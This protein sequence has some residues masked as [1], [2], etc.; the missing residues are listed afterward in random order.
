M[1]RFV[2]I[3]CLLVLFFSCSSDP[4]FS[5]IER[6]IPLR[7]FTVANYVY[8]VVEFDGKFYASHLAL[9]SKSSSS[10]DGWNRITA[11]DNNRSVLGLAVGDDG[12]NLY[13]LSI[14]GTVYYR[15]KG[16]DSWTAVTGQPANTAVVTLIGTGKKAFAVLRGATEGAVALTSGAM[17]QS[18][19]S[20][21]SAD[22]V[23]CAGNSTIKFSTSYSL[24]YNP[25]DDKFYEGSEI[26]G[27]V[28]SCRNAQYYNDGNSKCIVVGSSN[29]NLSR[30]ELSDTGIMT[31]NVRKNDLANESS[32]IA[33]ASIFH[34]GVWVFK[35]TI[36]V[37]TY[38]DENSDKNG[39]WGYYKSRGNWNKE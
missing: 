22:T 29:G 26:T 10:H 31:G 25:D 21:T 9:S 5:A 16:S 24:T 39:L 19:E 30:I 4:I 27:K 18:P 6:E 8:S 11:P 20:G 23:K 1:K 12:N 15:S 7:E 36:F 14:T 3:L 35:D 33:V 37:A 34:G 2:F 38:D 13:A 32:T 28:S 17:A